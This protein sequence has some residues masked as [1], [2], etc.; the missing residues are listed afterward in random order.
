MCEH[1]QTLYKVSCGAFHYCLYITDVTALIFKRPAGFEYRSGQWIRIACLDLGG[2]EYHPFTL[3]SA[4]HE[5]FLSL[6]IRAVGPWTMNIRQ[7][8][9]PSKSFLLYGMH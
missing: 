2:D 3:T 8:V 9:D 6:H 7:A 4:P 5:D 1:E